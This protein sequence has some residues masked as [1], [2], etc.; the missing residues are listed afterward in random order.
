MKAYNACCAFYAELSAK[1][2]SKR[3][4]NVRTQIEG[5]ASV[6][7]GNNESYTQMYVGTLLMSLERCQK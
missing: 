6:A 2:E 7:S 1:L 5:F 3:E 4:N